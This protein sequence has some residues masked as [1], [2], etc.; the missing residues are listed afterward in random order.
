MLFPFPTAELTCFTYSSVFEFFI[1][2]L[3][4]EFNLS[5]V[6]KNSYDPDISLMV[7]HSFTAL[8]KSSN[9]FF[10][11]SSFDTMLEYMLIFSYL[12]S[13]DA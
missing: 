8:Y 5:I 10:F 12:K 11:C 3:I 4:K 2:N 6:T 13:L 7:W 1:S 9:C